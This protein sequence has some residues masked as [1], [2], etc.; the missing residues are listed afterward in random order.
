MAMKPVYVWI[1]ASGRIPAVVTLGVTVRQFDSRMTAV[2][3]WSKAEEPRDCHLSEAVCCGN[4]HTA[5]EC[6]LRLKP[7][8]VHDDHSQDDKP[9]VSGESL[10]SKISTQNW[11][12]KA[13]PWNTGVFLGALKVIRSEGEIVFILS[14]EQW[15]SYCRPKNLL[16]ISNPLYGNPLRVCYKGSHG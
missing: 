12:M 6:L 16:K 3:I 9:H 1:K 7:A 14:N 10:K 15:Q 2:S 8:L 5:S 4:V 11:K 13:S